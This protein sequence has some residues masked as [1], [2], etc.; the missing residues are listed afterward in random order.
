MTAIPE[1]VVPLAERTWQETARLYLE[2]ARPKVMALVVFTAVPALALGRDG[3]PALSTAFIVLLAT[4]LAGAASSA[5]NA[6]VE[7]DTDALMA[8]TRNRPLPAAMLLPRVVLG[9]GIALTVISTV[10]LWAVGGPLA[11]GV[12][13]ATIAFYVGVY[14]IWLKP[15]TPQN[16]VIGGAAGATAPLI[17]SAAMDGTLS[18]GAWLLFGIVFLWTPPHFWAIAIYRRRDYARAGFPMMNQVVGDQGTRWRS[19]AYTAVLVPFT[20]LP[21]YFGYLGVGY[22][23]AAVVLGAWFGGW[24]IRSLVA[25]RAMVDRKVFKASTVYLMLLF[26][27]MIAD[28]L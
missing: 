28:L 9:Y 8:R 17:A 23:V 3:W 27:A 16:I 20:L 18:L 6:Y 10:M 13:L 25:R 2:V 19:L 12:G 14:T 4:A 22:A 26:V 21:V 5:L 11:A 7:R 1:P 24:V 15:R